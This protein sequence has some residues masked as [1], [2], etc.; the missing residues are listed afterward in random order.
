MRALAQPAG[1]AAREAAGGACTEKLTEDSVRNDDD[2]CARSYH[3]GE[4]PDGRM[5]AAAGRRNITMRGA[6][7][8]LRP[9]DFANFRWIVG[10]DEANRRSM[11]IALEHWRELGDVALPEDAE[12]RIVSMADFIDDPKVDRVPDPYYG[13]TKG[14][15]LVLDLLDGATDNLLDAVVERGGA[16]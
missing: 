8:P 10:M 2:A 7:R 14:F 13:G 16:A 1:G 6:S 12:E 9:S 11:L 15:D 4:P 5:T 3:E